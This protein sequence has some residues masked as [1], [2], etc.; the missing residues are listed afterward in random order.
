MQV[1]TP[2]TLYSRYDLKISIVCVCVFLGD[3][4][5]DERK[6]VYPFRGIVKEKVES[7]CEKL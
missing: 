7:H 1:L 4:T 6:G 2:G 5:K 3:G